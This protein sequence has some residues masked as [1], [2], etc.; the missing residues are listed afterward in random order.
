[1]SLMCGLVAF[2]C[3]NVVIYR[4]YTSVSKKKKK[5][6]D[7]Y[8]FSKLYILINKPIKIVLHHSDNENSILHKM[9]HVT[10]KVIGPKT[11]MY[12]CI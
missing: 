10:C 5:K 4:P 2:L 8:L 9:S 12:M 3:Q 6:K 11:K 7:K 1:M